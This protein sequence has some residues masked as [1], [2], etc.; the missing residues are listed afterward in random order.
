MIRLHTIKAL[1]FGYS[2][3]KVCIVS[4]VDVSLPAFTA[5]EMFVPPLGPL[6][7]KLSF[8]N[9]SGQC[10]FS[11]FIALNCLSCEQ[12][13]VDFNKQCIQVKELSTQYY[14]VI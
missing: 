4:K 8:S 7:Y 2:E 11:S 10:T 13:F 6:S 12:I 14:I 3:P 9:L 5:K 1:L